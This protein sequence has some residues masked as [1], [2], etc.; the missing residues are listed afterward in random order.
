[1]SKNPA[2]GLRGP[3]L[4][5]KLPPAGDRAGER[6]QQHLRAARAALFE[7]LC[8]GGSGPRSELISYV[9]EAARAVSRDLGA[10]PW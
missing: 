4:D 7:R 3:K 9:R 5:R 2:D 10:I 1:M 8:D 6:G